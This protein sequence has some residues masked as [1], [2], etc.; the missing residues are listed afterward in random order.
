[1]EDHK[2]EVTE[3]VGARIKYIR[4]NLSMS[5]EE[6]ALSANL[7]PAYFGLV[8]RGLK[9]PTV[10]T[11]CKI[12]AALSVSP[13]ELLKIDSPP[14]YTEGQS[15]RMQAIL[16]RIPQDKIDQALAV[17]ENLVALM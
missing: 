16:S 14:S 5:Q 10:D 13:S 4:Q 8:E 11:I 15:Q 12:A 6:V 9:C 7:N 3:A 17:F 1:M 2:R